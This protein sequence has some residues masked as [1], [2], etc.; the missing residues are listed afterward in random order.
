MSIHVIETFIP[1]STMVVVSWFS[2]L[3]PPESFPGRVAVLV[4]LL[5]VLINCMLK[6]LDYSPVVG[7]CALSEWTLICLCMV[8]YWCD[9]V[10]QSLIHEDI[11]LNFF[12]RKFQARKIFHLS[13]RWFWLCLNMQSSSISWGSETILQKFAARQVN[14]HL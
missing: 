2:F 14:H 7:S 5:L 4:T 12:L 11:P 3:I 10:W 6:I 8:K 1:T 13:F 9:K